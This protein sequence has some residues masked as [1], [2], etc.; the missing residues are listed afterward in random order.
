[1]QIAVAKLAAPV[2]TFTFTV[3]GD[4]QWTIRSVCAVATRA[5]GGIPN[6]AYTLV[7]TNGTVTVAAVGADDAGTEPGSCTVTWAN[8]PGG[9]TASAATGISI[10]PL[11]PLVLPPGYKLTGTIVGAVAGDTWASAVAWYDYTYTGRR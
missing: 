2:T 3:P 1:L 9:T 6:R 5:A 10:A 4:Q 7:V 11:G 8:T